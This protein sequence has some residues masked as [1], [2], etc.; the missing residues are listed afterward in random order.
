VL[1]VVLTMVKKELSE[2]LES[3]QALRGLLPQEMVMKTEIPRND[4]YVQASARGLP[5]GVM[6]EGAET[7]STFEQLRLELEQRISPPIPT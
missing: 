7:L 1:G 5:V 6:E 3:A 2:S 4:L